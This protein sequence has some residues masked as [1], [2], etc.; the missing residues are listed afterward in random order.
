MCSRLRGPYESHL[1]ILRP[2]E[3]SVLAHTLGEQLKSE[4][5]MG[6]CGSPAEENV[7]MGEAGWP[8]L[9]VGAAMACK[10]TVALRYEGCS[11]GA[12]EG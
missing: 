7:L 6:V 3:L 4:S 10:R 12:G 8:A 11:T 5:M 2:Q 1:P 9:G